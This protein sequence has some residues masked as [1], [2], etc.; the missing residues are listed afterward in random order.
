MNRRFPPKEKLLW[1]VI[2]QKGIVFFSHFSVKK[3]AVGAVIVSFLYCA[4]VF[5]YS[6][7]CLKEIKILPPMAKLTLH[8]N[9]RILKKEKPLEAYLTNVENRNIFSFSDLN[10]VQEKAVRVNGMDSMKDIMLVAILLGENPQAAI[11][12]KNTQKIFYVTRGQFVGEL[13]VDDIQEGKVFLN[14][15]GTRYEFDL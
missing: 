2:Q 14:Y 10:S 11:Q 5:G 12:N 4:I 3:L 6:S 8:N 1:L 7:A 15:N 9:K 13:Q